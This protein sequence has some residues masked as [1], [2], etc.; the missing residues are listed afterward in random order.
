VTTPFSLRRSACLVSVLTSQVL[1][2]CHAKSKT[3][4]FRVPESGA[5]HSMLCRPAHPRPHK[6]TEALFAP[7][8][9]GEQTAP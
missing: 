2:L 6:P 5:G 4:R 3:G 9:E 8:R 1:A 7:M